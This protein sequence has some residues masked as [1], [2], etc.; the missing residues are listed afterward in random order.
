MADSR[1]RVLGAVRTAL[2]GSTSTDP[3]AERLSRHPSGPL[4]RLAGTDLHE[5]FLERWETAAGTFEQLPHADAVPAAV[6]RYLEEHGLVAGAL[7]MAD[8][9]LLRARAWPDHIQPAYRSARP[10]DQ[11]A[12]MVAYAGL[13]E[14]GT[15]VFLAGSDSPTSLNFLPDHLICILPRSRLLEHPEALWEELRKREQGMPRAVN[16]VTGPSRTADVEQKL[17]LGAHGPRRVHLLITGP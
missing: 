7:A 15:L 12:V 14:T 4:P 9:P 2:G 10:D 5:G 6:E 16:L 1:E 13:A 3:V 17:Q 11:T 8:H